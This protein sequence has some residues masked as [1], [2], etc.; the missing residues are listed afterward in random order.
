[1]N[2]GA[3]AGAALRGATAGQPLLSLAI[4]AVAAAASG[5]VS[6]LR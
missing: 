6:R 4:A 1:M 5:V 3:A 2:G